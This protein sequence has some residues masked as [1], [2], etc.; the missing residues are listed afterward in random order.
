MNTMFIRETSNANKTKRNIII[1]LIMYFVLMMNG[2][3][4]KQ[5]TVTLDRHVVV[6]QW[7]NSSTITIYTAAVPANY[8]NE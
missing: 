3:H 5:F 7:L 1:V 6:V 2:F 4:A 8:N